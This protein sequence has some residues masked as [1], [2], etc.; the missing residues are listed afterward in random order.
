MPLRLQLLPDLPEVVHLAV[1]A[2]DH[3]PVGGSHRLGS[4]FRQV[5]DRQTPVGE[6]RPPVGGEVDPGGIRAPVDHRAPHRPEQSL[7]RADLP[8]GHESGYPAHRVTGSSLRG[9]FH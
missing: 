5:K 1:V 9:G 2:K 7:P 6:T 3:R 8:G 4:R